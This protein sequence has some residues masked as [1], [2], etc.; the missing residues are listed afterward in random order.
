MFNE[1]SSIA[2]TVLKSNFRILCNIK[3]QLKVRRIA[4]KEKWFLG[5]DYKIALYF[6]LHRFNKLVHVVIFS[7]TYIEKSLG[8]IRDLI[9]RFSRVDNAEIRCPVPVIRG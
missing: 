7:I 4:A 8:V 1:K 5:L 9:K 2:R 6:S 3:K